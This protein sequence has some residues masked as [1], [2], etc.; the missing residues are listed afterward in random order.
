MT[1]LH[2]FSI[3]MVGALLLLI[4]VPFGLLKYRIA[5]AAAF[6]DAVEALPRGALDQVAA[7]CERLSEERGGP[8]AGLE[9]IRDTNILAQ[10]TLAGRRPYEIVVEQDTVGLKFIKG[11]WR[12]STLA[13]WEK[14]RSSSKET[15]AVLKII[16][17]S[18]GW[19]ILSQRSEPVGGTNESQ[20]LH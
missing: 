20:S 15:I 6:C 19:R 16:D 13:I 14:D 9:F 1:R 17:G 18:T 5:K 2:W 7:R 8:N 12:Y 11:N 3:T 10:F 4:G